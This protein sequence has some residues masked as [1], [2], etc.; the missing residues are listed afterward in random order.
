MIVVVIIGILAAIAI[1]KFTLF[2]ATAKQHEA[3]LL[4]KQ[5]YTLQEAYMQRYSS[6]AA[7]VDELE[8][9]GWA[10][11]QSLQ[12][13]AQPTIIVGGGPGSTVYTACMAALQPGL[14]SRSIDEAKLLG[15]C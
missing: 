12:H 5:I 10:P 13:F 3:D 7:T 1:P 11:P 4:L 6:Y 2:A 9:V 14:T 8:P 15:T